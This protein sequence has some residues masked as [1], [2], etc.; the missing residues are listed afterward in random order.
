MN[1]HKALGLLQ[2][3]ACF[4]ACSLPLQGLCKIHYH[5][6]VVAPTPYT[7]LCE[8]KDI[9][10]ING[11]FPGPTLYLNKG[12]KLLV[13]V[14]NRAP[15]PLTIHWHGLLN[16]RNPW[17]D[18]PEFITMCGIK[19]GENFTHDLQ[20]TSEEGTLWYH[21]HSDWTRVTVHGAVVIYPAVGTTYPFP[22][23][24]EEYVVALGE[25]WLLNVMYMYEQKVTTGADFN[26]SDAYLINSQP[27]ALYNCSVADI[28]RFKFEQGKTY[29]LRL[30]NG[31]MSDALFFAIANH[32]LTV[33]G[34]DGSYLKPFDTEYAIISPGQTMDII[35]NANQKKGLYYMGASAYIA[36]GEITYADATTT[37]ALVEYESH[38]SSDASPSMPSIPLYNDIAASYKFA[39][40]LRSLANEDHP[41]DVPRYIDTRLMFTVSM[42]LE[43]CPNASC[44]GINGT[45]FV[46]SMNNISFA[47][48]K[49]DILEAYYWSLKGIFTTDFPSFP[50]YLFN[51]TSDEYQ[52]ELMYPES[53][54]R[55]KVLNYNSSVE[56]V[57]QATNLLKADN[58]P[59]HLH[60]F[61][62]YVVGRGFGNFDPNK[63][64]LNYNLVD[65]PLLNTVAVPYLGWAAVRFKANNP[66]VW[67]LHCHFERHFTWGMDTV[68]IVKDG[69]TNET[70]MLPP[71]PYMP[72]C[73]DS[74]LQ[75]KAKNE[76]LWHPSDH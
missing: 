69:P 18:G 21:A 75:F 32:T 36:S 28:T 6:F 56:L 17:H 3:L 13:N 60:G 63:D 4:L 51:F 46:S 54:T 14:I 19:P 34:R 2:I 16:P 39:T 67:L 50:P 55:A 43:N 70:S 53:G 58:H 22:A 41:I 7:R 27:G 15:Y 37:T 61:D 57:F 10:T 9:L 72:K 48:P 76:D 68:F 26:K 33:V 12:D 64:P 24:H 31:A 1:P 29:L 38:N 5:D 74:H 52:D 71:P 49:I 25:W 62:F 11:Q 20:F 45:R 59:M 30:L 40:Q 8:T 65:P 35:V 66:G 47:N 73:T 44:A 42:N 23:P